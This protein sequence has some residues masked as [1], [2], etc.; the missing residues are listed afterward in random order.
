MKLRQALW[1]LPDKPYISLYYFCK[2]KRFCNF[3]NPK[4]FSE[5]MQ[6][7]KLYD[8][9]VEYTVM[10]DKYE[11]K[12]YVAEMIGQEY[13]TPLLGVWERVED[14][15]FAALPEQFVL[16][17]TH[18]SGGLVICKDKHQLDTE[19]AKKALNAS[20]RCNYYRTAREWPYKDVKPKVIAEEYMENDENEG[21]HDYKIWCFDGCPKYVQYI[22]GR[23]NESF[24]GF[25]DKDWVL[26]SFSYHN[27]LM[28]EPVP[29]PAK[30]QEM[31]ALAQKLSEG[32]PV[33]RVDFYI[34]PDDSIR[35]GEITFYPMS[36]FEHWHPEKMDTIIGDMITIKK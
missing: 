13:V 24:E 29:R 16:K 22:T 33:A 12:R 6:W 35:F 18:D 32:L 31:L 23:N 8:R 1:L 3:R 11:A 4:T 36:G 17:C 19:Q 14:I 9:K 15:D 26:Q 34:L 30:L 21:L 5:K 10:V 7:L 28:K 2:F 25:Y 27:P 20:L